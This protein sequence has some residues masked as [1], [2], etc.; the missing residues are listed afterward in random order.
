M[1]SKCTVCG[2]FYSMRNTTRDEDGMCFTCSFWTE[3]SNYRNYTPEGFARNVIVNHKA[4]LMS[5]ND[6]EGG[7]RGF[8]GSEWFVK[9][10]N[11]YRVCCRNMWHQ[12]NIPKRFWKLLPDN[13]KF[14]WPKKFEQTALLRRHYV[15]S[16]KELLKVREIGANV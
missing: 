12:G 13:A 5:P 6:Q 16:T 1:T 4:Y 7:F 3:H 8:G 11:G 2:K 10:N 15:E 9:F 14:V